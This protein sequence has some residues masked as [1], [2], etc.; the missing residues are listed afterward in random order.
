MIVKS[1]DS[2]T[3][4]LLSKMSVTCIFLLYFSEGKKLF[5]LFW[6]IVLSTNLA[7]LLVVEAQGLI[8]STVNHWSWSLS[9]SAAFCKFWF[10][11]MM[12]LYSLVLMLRVW[13]TNNDNDLPLESYPTS[14]NSLETIRISL[15]PIGSP[16][17]CLAFVRLC[18]VNK[19]AIDFVWVPGTSLSS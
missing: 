1:W 3:A 6:W 5:W 9:M 19:D 10:L 13:W 16:V 17:W 15:F 7:R 2:D 4:Q 12:L 11:W 14:I 8:I 18:I